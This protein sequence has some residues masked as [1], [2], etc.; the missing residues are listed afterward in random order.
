MSNENEVPV[1]QTAAECVVPRE[2]KVIVR[3]E[4]QRPA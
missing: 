2:V 1:L 3:G 4:S